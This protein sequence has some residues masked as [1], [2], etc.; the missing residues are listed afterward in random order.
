[1]PRTRIAKCFRGIA[2]LWALVIIQVFLKTDLPV[3]ALEFVNIIVVVGVFDMEFL[4]AADR[5][6]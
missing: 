5:A 3:P 2:D 1:M 6:F 4:T